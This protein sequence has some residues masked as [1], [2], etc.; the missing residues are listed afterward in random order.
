M[1]QSESLKLQTMWSASQCL[2]FSSF[3]GGRMKPERRLTILLVSVKYRISETYPVWPLWW[4]GW[5]KQLAGFPWMGPHHTHT[6]HARNEG[7]LLCFLFW[8]VE[9]CMDYIYFTKCAWNISKET[10]MRGRV[11]FM[12]NVWTHLVTL[13]NTFLG[14]IYGTIFFIMPKD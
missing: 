11:D 14:G 2:T 8:T 13:Q 12:V 1:L 4:S 7:F 10:R 9:Q 3:C 5:A 6:Q